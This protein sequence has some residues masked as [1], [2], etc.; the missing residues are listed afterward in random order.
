MPQYSLKIQKAN[1]QIEEFDPQKFVQSLKHAGV[2]ERIAQ[3]VLSDMEKLLVEGMSTHTIY[4][5]AFRLLKQHSRTSAAKYNLKR[6]IMELGPSG[7]PFERLIGELW[8]RKGYEVEIGK[9][10]KG[11]CVSHEVDVFAQNAEE[12]MFI[13]CKFHNQPGHKNDIKI[14]LYVRSRFEDIKER[15]QNNAIFQHKKFSF[16]LATNTRFTKDALDYGRCSGMYLLAWDEP[17]HLSLRDLIY[18]AELHPLTCLTN[19]SEKAKK[20]LLDQKL[21]TCRDVLEQPEHL[22]NY[23]YSAPRIERVLHEIDELFTF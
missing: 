10:L 6:A 19:V 2:E 5:K 4:R 9:V 18:E 20:F 14:P 16:G 1:G 17:S 21:I 7:Y 15:M 13:E 8:T 22:R 23:G 11:K 12:V 3:H